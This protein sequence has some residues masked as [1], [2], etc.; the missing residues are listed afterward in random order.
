[1]IRFYS[2]ADTRRTPTTSGG[3]TLIELLVVIAIIAILAAILFPVFAQAREKARAASCLSNTKQVG[4]GFMMYVQDYDESFPYW[5]WWYSSDLGGGPYGPH[6]ESFGHYESMWF[7]AIYPYMKNG[8]IYNCPSANDHT[9]IT[10]NAIWAWTKA[11][12]LTTVGITP[13]LTSQ[14]I[15]LGYNQDISEGTWA[16]GNAV[17]LSALVKPAQTDLVSDCASGFAYLGAGL[18]PDSTNPND[19]KHN[20]IMTRIAFPNVPAGSWGTDNCGACSG[21]GAQYASQMPKLATYLNQARH[22]QGDNLTFADG[23]SK[24][25]RATTIT[26]DYMFGDF[27]Q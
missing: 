10:Q 17:T 2:G 24:W 3:F 22:T 12:D 4:L 18:R 16:G 21:G 27:A 15:N 19:P 6:Q 9:T 26:A 20:L 8:P 11:T 5:S 14:S 25:M 1:M 7:S 13:S 23:H